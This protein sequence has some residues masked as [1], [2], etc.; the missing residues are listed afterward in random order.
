MVTV[1]ST[2]NERSLGT[3][4]NRKKTLQQKEMNGE[5]LTEI[6]EPL[7]RQFVGHDGG[8]PF[9]VAGG[10]LVRVE[11]QR[12]FAERHQAPVF[13]GAADKVRNADQVWPRRKQKSRE[14]IKMVQFLKT[15]P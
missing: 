6:A 15:F 4:A 7:V 9:L 13:H 8:H 12:R 10:A 11:Q 2:K 3:Q 14:P 5:K 1:T